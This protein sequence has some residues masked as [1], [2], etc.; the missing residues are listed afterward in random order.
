VFEGR[1][2]KHAEERPDDNLRRRVV[3]R[4]HAPDD[5]GDRVGRE[6][7]GGGGGCGWGDWAVCELEHG[8]RAEVEQ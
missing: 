2:G 7:G 8:A 5:R 1:C 6:Q 4:P 3:P